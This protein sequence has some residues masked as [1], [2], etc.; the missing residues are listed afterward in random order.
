MPPVPLECFGGPLDGSVLAAPGKIWR[1]GSR[2]LPRIIGVRHTEVEI[3][4]EDPF[5][6]YHLYEKKGAAWIYAGRFE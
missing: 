1:V 6:P 4:N 5:F 2:Y 3:P